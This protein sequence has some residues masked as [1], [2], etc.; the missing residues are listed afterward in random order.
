MSS[1]VVGLILVNMVGIKRY[2]KA[3]ALFGIILS[4][5]GM[6]AVPLSGM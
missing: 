3:L 5:G 1:A 2:P 6:I 4:V